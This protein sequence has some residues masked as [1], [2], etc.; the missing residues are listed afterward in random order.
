MFQ[1]FALGNNRNS[2]EAI[3]YD[4]DDGSE[5]YNSFKPQVLAY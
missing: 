4:L 3:Y 1:F 2:T 5:I